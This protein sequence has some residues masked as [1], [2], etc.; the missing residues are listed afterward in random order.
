MAGGGYASEGRPSPFRMFLGVMLPKDA[1]GCLL[2]IHEI[3]ARGE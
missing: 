2:D 3:E 1:G